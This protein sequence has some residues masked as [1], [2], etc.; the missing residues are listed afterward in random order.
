MH[1]VR[2]NIER[3]SRKIDKVLN[4]VRN[5]LH[6]K[7]EN[8]PYYQA[9]HDY[10][11]KSL[12]V[13]DASTHALRADQFIVGLD[14]VNA[15]FIVFSDTNPDGYKLFAYPFE[16]AIHNM[17]TIDGENNTTRVRARPVPYVLRHVARLRDYIEYDLPW[18][19]DN[20][21]NEIQTHNND[22]IATQIDL[23]SS[24][25]PSEYLTSSCIQGW[26]D[27]YIQLQEDAL[28]ACDDITAEVNPFITYLDGVEDRAAVESHIAQQTQQNNN[29]HD[30]KE[31][32]NEHD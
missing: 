31:N 23:I 13:V 22:G 29:Q 18:Y 9:F 4:H 28:Q 3:L 12:V 27:K 24:L 25:S 20:N 5:C 1:N 8:P 30:P 32:G 7:G 11:Y 10:L 16:D 2:E 15:R 26:K 17:N 19:Y 21:H 6:E 14:K